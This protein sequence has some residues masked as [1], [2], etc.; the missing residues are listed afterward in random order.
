VNLVQGSNEWLEFRRGKIGAS[1][2]P[3][4]LE[5][6]PWATPY[7]LWL[8]KMELYCKPKNFAMQRG[9]ALEPLARQAFMDYTGH[10]VKPAVV[11]NPQYEWMIASL[12]GVTPDK[13]YA[14]EIK[15]AGK[16]DHAYVERKREPPKKYISQLQHQ[17]YVVGL[18]MIYYYSFDGA[19]G[20]CVEYYRDEDFIA[21][22]LQKELEFWNNMLNFT[23]PEMIKRDYEYLAQI[24]WQAA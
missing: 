10:S 24:W 1:D 16:T 2:A 6:S 9:V 17:M 15:C 5:Q 14:V 20:I 23:P 12:D 19:Q 18:D 11:Q 13:R 21:Q 7:Q 4:I 3:V 22:L 8:E